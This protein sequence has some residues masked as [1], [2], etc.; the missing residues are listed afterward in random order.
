MTGDV[1]IL[2]ID[3]ALNH[4]GF[5]QL[6]ALG[7]VDR[8]LVVT[9]VKKAAE[10]AGDRGVLLKKVDAED[11]QAI[12]LARLQWWDAFLNAIVK[13]WEPTHVVVEDYALRA[14]SNAAYNI[15]EQGGVVRLAVLKRGRHLR[16]HEPMTVKMFAGNG[17]A[18]GR[19]LADMV[20]EKWKVNFKDCNPPETPRGANTIPEEDLCAAYVLAR[21]GW[22]ELELRASRLQLSQLDEKQIQVFNRVTK[23]NPINLLGREWL[24]AKK[25][26]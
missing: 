18:T 22:T 15:G 14:E 12:Q 19:E 8:Y 24:T 25:P 17:N 9:D 7:G 3:L 1:K 5:V 20:T 26:L 4:A 2:G 10:R 23:A 21:M 6:D 11:R 16:M 13:S